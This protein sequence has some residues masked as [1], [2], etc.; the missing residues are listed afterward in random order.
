MTPEPVAPP[1]PRPLVFPDVDP[2]ILADEDRESR[3]PRA[4]GPWQSYL[5]RVLPPRDDSTSN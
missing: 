5:R 4:I 1:F 3:N 2:A